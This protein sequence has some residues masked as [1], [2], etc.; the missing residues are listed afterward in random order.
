MGLDHHDL[1]DHPN[2][3]ETRKTLSGE[4]PQVTI[5]AYFV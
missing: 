3:I 4:L 1:I 2:N 5:Q